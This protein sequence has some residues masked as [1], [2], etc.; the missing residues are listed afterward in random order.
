MSDELTWDMIEDKCGEAVTEE[1]IKNADSGGG[2]SVGKYLTEV[3]A[4][5]PTL[6]K[7]K[8][9]PSYYVAK[10]KHKV[11][12]VI[13][14][15]RKPVSGDEG[16]IY[17]GRFIWD[18][19]SMP[20]QDESDAIRNRRITIAKRGGIISD[21]STNIPN[22]AFSKLIIGKKYIVEVVENQYTDENGNKKSNNQIAMFGYHSVDEIEKVS[23][24]DIADI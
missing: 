20:T 4:S 13:E 6:A 12:R 2:V 24:N 15:N 8:G 7:P 22:N 11:E 3:I 14:I 5:Y 17:I 16:D 19:V 1:D 23:E 9:K 18:R 21:S 10:L